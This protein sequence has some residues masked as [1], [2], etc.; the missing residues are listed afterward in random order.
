MSIR[1]GIAA[2]GT[3]GHI[4][5]ALQVAKAIQKLGGECLWVGRSAS[6]ESK[7][8][9]TH[10]IPFQAWVSRVTSHHWRIPR[11]AVAI[12]GDVLKIRQH[13]RRHPIDCLF[14]TGAF[15]SLP[16]A[17]A[18]K[19]LGIPLVIQEQNTVM[20]KANTLLMRMADGVCLGMPISGLPLSWVTGNPI[21]KRSMAH[22]GNKVLIMGGSQGCK[23]LNEISPKVLKNNQINSGIIHIAGNHHQVV[24]EVYQNLGMEAE[25]HPFVDDMA[26]VY[27]QAKFVIAR[28]GAMTLAEL[29]GYAKPA[30]VVPYPHAAGNHQRHNA[31]H[32]VNKNAALLAEES[33]AS[34][35]E[36]L[37]IM[38]SDNKMQHLADTISQLNP[39]NA[40]QEIIKI[41]QQHACKLPH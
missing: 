7:I 27:Q 38:L 3:G 19:S 33:A 30:I 31:M 15:V 28:A 10:D 5:P 37:S 29:S 12:T 25:V 41:I 26:H 32:Y 34:L 35:Q 2:G 36:A 21:P 4:V 20:G 23:F 9:H 40:V 17:L 13:L 8:A 6:M 22:I 24:A 39:P 1:L 14:A 11:L 16:T 18:A